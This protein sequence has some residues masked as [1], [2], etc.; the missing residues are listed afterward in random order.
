MIPKKLLA[1]LFGEVSDFHG[2]PDTD[3]YI[4]PRLEGNYLILYRLSRSN[5]IPFDERS[6]AHH[7]GDYL[8]APLVGYQVEYC[9]PEKHETARFEKTDLDV[10][11]C[12]GVPMS[13]AKY[14]RFQTSGRQE[15]SYQ[16]KL[17]IFPADFF[18]GNWFYLKTVVQTSEQ[19]AGSIGHRPFV[20][21]HLVEFRKRPN[22]LEV[23]DASGYELLDKDKVA[24]VFIPV[25]W[26]EYK[27][28][29]N[30][31]LF[32]S[33]SETER[34]KNPDTKRPYFQMDFQKLTV[35]ETG[36]DSDLKAVVRGVYIT[37]D[38]F[39][40]DIEVN[41]EAGW[42]TLVRYSFKKSAPNPDYPEK[43]WYKE[44]TDRFMPVF[45]SARRYYKRSVDT[46]IKDREKFMRA[47]R[48][49]PGRDAIVW[50][51]FLSDLCVTSGFVISAGALLSIRTSCLRRPAGRRAGR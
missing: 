17:D 47:N 49:D 8:A 45:A 27:M 7:V 18:K 15:F 20:S 2:F 24:A 32:N 36:G 31:D 42:P 44:D 6:M 38:Y 12:E 40:F 30:A 11:V 9:V 1:F 16:P 14:V 35:L 37:D 50:H 51:F 3:Y 21:S 43:A 10:A 4:L 39:S 34:T 23:V 25:N 33:F 46:T 5:K 19:T 22:H 26:K 41:K 13:S 29:R 48:F 28:D